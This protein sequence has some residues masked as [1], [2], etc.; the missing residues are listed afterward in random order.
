MYSTCMWL[1]RESFNNVAVDGG[2][3]CAICY[4][5]NK[6]WIRFRFD[7]EF[8]SEWKQIG[9][10][11][12]VYIKLASPHSISIAPNSSVKGHLVVCRK[13]YNCQ[14]S[15]ICWINSANGLYL[16]VP[17]KKQPLL[18]FRP[19]NMVHLHTTMW[20]MNIFIHVTIVSLA[21]NICYHSTSGNH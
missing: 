17:K 19:F 20:I 2:A 5:I 18:C 3:L 6:Q 12:I 13:D 21:F 7:S 14:P 16:L 4:L 8:V 9:T 10:E 1:R 15:A 11:F